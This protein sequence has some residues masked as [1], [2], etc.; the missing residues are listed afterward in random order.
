M[1][2]VDKFKRKNERKQNGFTSSKQI[3]E[4]LNNEITVND[5][6][7]NKKLTKGKILNN[8]DDDKINKNNRHLLIKFIQQEADKINDDFNIL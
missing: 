1:N 2:A 6:L 4:Q 7:Y 3:N 8:T 5:I